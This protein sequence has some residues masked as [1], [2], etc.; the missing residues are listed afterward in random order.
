V[1]VAPDRGW[2]VAGAP[3][4]SGIAEAPDDQAAAA[5]AAASPETA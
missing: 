4:T 2:L 5:Q 1:R 3:S